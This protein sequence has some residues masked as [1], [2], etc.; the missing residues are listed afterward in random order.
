MPSW[1]SPQPSTPFA[2]VQPVIVSTFATRMPACQVSA[3]QAR[4]NSRPEASRIMWSSR[5]IRFQW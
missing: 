2:T 1:F 5:T 4:W 3:G